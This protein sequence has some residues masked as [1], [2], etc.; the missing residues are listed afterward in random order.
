MAATT[1]AHASSTKNILVNS[2]IFKTQPC[3]VIYI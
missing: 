1:K 3:K 2:Y